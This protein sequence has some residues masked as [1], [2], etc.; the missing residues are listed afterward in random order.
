MNIN[1]KKRTAFFVLMLSLL[2]PFTASANPIMWTLN[3]FEFNDGGFA[4]GSFVFDADT[5][6]FSEVNITTTA[7]STL[8][9]DTYGFA[10]PYSGRTSG[11]FATS[12]TADYTD[13]L[14][15]FFNID[16]VMSNAGGTLNVFGFNSYDIGDFAWG[17]GICSDSACGDY[18]DALTSRS[19][20]VNSTPTITG[21]AVDVPSP[22]T[23]SLLMLGLIAAGLVRRK[24]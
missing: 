4:I 13:Q 22:G 14:N 20:L 11:S 3:D 18:D 21:A 7:G 10:G 12:D 6:L 16:G 9:G 8:S 19:Y 15:F 24:S 2:L 1:N 17:E 23:L 5:A